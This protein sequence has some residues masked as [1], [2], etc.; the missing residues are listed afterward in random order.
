MSSGL[1]RIGAKHV[2]PLKRSRQSRSLYITTRRCFVHHFIYSSCNRSIV[3][4]KPNNSIKI[5]R[6]CV[7]RG[8]TSESGKMATLATNAAAAAASG[9][10]QSQELKCPTLGCDGSG[11]ATGNYAT[12][13]TLSGCPRASVAGTNGRS[14]TSTRDTSTEPL[15]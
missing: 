8:G 1:I 3:L 14:R 11:H 5:K 9:V 6:L 10:N 7:L 13:R 15:R 4:T 12:H 2:P